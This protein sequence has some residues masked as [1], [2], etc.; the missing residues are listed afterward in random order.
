MAVDLRSRTRGW[1]TAAV[2]PGRRYGEL[3]GQAAWYVAEASRLNATR[4]RL[5][6]QGGPDAVAAY[7]DF[8]RVLTWYG[9]ALLGGDNRV[10]GER[11]G[12]RGS[13]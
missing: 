4:P 5:S 11:A 7:F 6:Q 2:K 12:V 3:V 9:W 10:L 13:P 1:R 8:L